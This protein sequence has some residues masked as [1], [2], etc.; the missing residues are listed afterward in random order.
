MAYV[1]KY[2]AKF[3]VDHEENYGMELFY[4]FEEWM[5]IVGK[6]VEGKEQRTM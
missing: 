5:Q 1:P 4:P 2:K 3:D 6:Y